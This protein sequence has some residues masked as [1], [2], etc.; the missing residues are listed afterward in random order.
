M[1]S[2]RPFVMRY[3]RGSFLA[4]L[5]LLGACASSSPPPSQPAT[6]VPVVETPPSPPPPASDTPS[7]AAA[8]DTALAAPEP[9]CQAAEDCKK[10]HEP[11]PGLQ[12]TC[13]NARCLEQPVAEAPK[14]E[15]PAEPVT[16]EKAV[17]KTKGKGKKK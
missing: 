3:G 16:A 8:T 7:Q 14:P 13:E 2:N 17:K 5:L 11:A 12:W 10:L 9:E 15:Q 1:N 4:G 6:P